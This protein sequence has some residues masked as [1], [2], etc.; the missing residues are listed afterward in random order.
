MSYQGYW[1]S[2]APPWAADPLGLGW[3]G[4]YGK[5]QDYEISRIRGAALSC[6]PDF[7]ATDALAQIGAEL[8]IDRASADTDASYATRLRKAWESWPFAGSGYGV[9]RALRD[10]GYT[11]CVLVQVNGLALSL[12]AN[13]D[14]VVTQLAP[15]PHVQ[16]PPGTPHPWWWYD[17]NTSFVSRF[18]LIFQPPVP[19]GWSSIVSPPTSVSA[20]AIPEVNLIRR[21]VHRWK[22]GSATFV[23][24]IVF[25]AGK[26]WGWPIRT[27]QTG[28]DKYGAATNHVVW[29]PDEQ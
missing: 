23:N 11:D 12:D 17:D 25:S 10:L 18:S 16:D 20:P 13:G 29:L 27:F 9:L 14:L 7:A 24:I 28:G 5:A 26:V 4:A 2:K 6:F 3:F 8:L 21:V 22:K 1:Q 15:N 19:A